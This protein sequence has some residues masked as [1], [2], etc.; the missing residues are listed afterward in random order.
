MSATPRP[1][2]YIKSSVS[3]FSD[4]TDDVERIKICDTSTHSKSVREAQENAALIVRAVNTFDEAKAVLRQI[5]QWAEQGGSQSDYAWYAH[6][7]AALAKM[8]GTHD[9]N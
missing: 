5:E 3:I 1:W 2:H 7:Q 9:T 8:E 6:L 4:E